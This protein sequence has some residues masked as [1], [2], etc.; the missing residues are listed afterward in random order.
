MAN[1]KL[2]D[3]TVEGEIELKKLVAH[4][5]SLSCWFEITPE[6]DDMYTVSVKEDVAH[7]AFAKHLEQTER[8][9]SALSLLH[10]YT[11]SVDAAYR[12]GLNET[13]ELYEKVHREMNSRAKCIVKDCANH[14]HEGLFVGDL[15]APCHSFITEVKGRDSQAFRNAELQA[16]SLK[17]QHGRLL[18][19]LKGLLMYPLGTF[20]VVA[21]KEAIAQAEEGL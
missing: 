19:A 18:D 10:A 2:V 11:R 17:I 15:C 21:A 6:P 5:C 9:S 8:D 12:N 1:V 7:I 3:K 14:K 13:V 20:Q 4:L 16:A